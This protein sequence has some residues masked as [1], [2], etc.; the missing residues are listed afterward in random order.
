MGFGLVLSGGG[1]RGIAHLGLLKVLEEIGVKPSIISGCSSGAIAGAL[2]ASGYS[3]DEILGIVKQIKPRKIIRPAL[4][5][6]G[7]LKMDVTETLYHQYITKDSFEELSI[8]LY[9]AATNLQLGETKYFST[10]ELIR[11]LMASSSV[12]VLFDPVCIGDQCYVDGGLL[13]NFPV[14]IIKD[15]CDK[16]LGF[17][18]NPVDEHFK[19]TNI[20]SM[21]ERTF[22]LTINA[23]ASI[24]MKSCD[25]VVEPPGLKKYKVFSFNNSDEL[26]DIGYQY[27]K[28]IEDQL[29]AFFDGM[30]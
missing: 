20:K 2:Y 6:T 9:V 18:C 17:H 12:P 15:K 26:F 27:G 16:V 1:T 8:P 28:S 24:Q 23:N 11:P 25:M 22:L 5:K 14:E 30:I 21:I 4:K 7:L 29:R 3:P 10:G 13:N 19:L